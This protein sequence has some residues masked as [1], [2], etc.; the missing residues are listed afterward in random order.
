MPVDP[1]HMISGPP[2]ERRRGAEGFFLARDVHGAKDMPIL[3]KITSQVRE[4]H[5][6][7]AGR[8]LSRPPERTMASGSYPPSIAY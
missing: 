3:N 1:V 6:L 8:S 7:S 2:S 5:H 4:K